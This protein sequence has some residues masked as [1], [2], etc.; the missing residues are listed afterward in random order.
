MLVTRCCNNRMR[1][2]ADLALPSSTPGFVVS[3]KQIPHCCN[4]R[5]NQPSNVSL[6]LAG[7]PAYAKSSS[8]IC[9][10]IHTKP[11][12]EHGVS[13]RPCS[14]GWMTHG[15]DV[16]TQ[17]TTQKNRYVPELE[18]TPFLKIRLHHSSA[19]IPRYS[20]GHRT[21]YGVSCLV[22]IKALRVYD[23]HG[24]PRRSRCRPHV[25]QGSWV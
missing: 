21:L 7:M 17:R 23:T 12:I 18:D 6:L 10:I 4:S 1:H 25:P 14:F 8:L 9:P 13:Q 20:L 22:E 16:S 3:C 19:H 2:T 5:I 15:S 11:C 24:P